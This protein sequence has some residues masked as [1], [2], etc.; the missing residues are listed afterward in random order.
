MTGEQSRVCEI[1]FSSPLNEALYWTDEN[2]HHE[3]AELER[4]S[5]LALKGEYLYRTD[6]D[7][8]KGLLSTSIRILTDKSHEI[9]ESDIKRFKRCVV[10]DESLSRSSDI[11]DREG[12]L[13]SAEFLYAYCHF[14][15]NA[16]EEIRK[17]DAKKLQERERWLQKRKQFENLLFKKPGSAGFLKT[18]ANKAD[19][20]NPKIFAEW[21]RL[22]GC[23][24][25]P[26]GHVRFSGTTV[27]FLNKCRDEKIQLPNLKE[28][29]ENV[30]TLYGHQYRLRDKR[31][32]EKAYNKVYKS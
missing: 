14:L 28:L 26:N 7:Y 27:G 19:K 10:A 32:W 8:W 2:N 20:N 30:E 18:E 4:L 25:L 9:D 23:D 1:V 6:L 22:T 29:S 17:R 24:L 31:L 3:T 15:W 12:L 11:I 16:P 13:H 5:S 21:K